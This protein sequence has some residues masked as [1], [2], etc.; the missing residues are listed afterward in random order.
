MFCFS[1][2]FFFLTS[3]SSSPD[4]WPTFTAASHVTVLLR[5][6]AAFCFP[7]QGR[8]EGLWGKPPLSSNAPPAIKNKK[9]KRKKKETGLPTPAWRPPCSLPAS[10]NKHRLISSATTVPLIVFSCFLF[11]SVYNVAV[12]NNDLL[13]CMCT[14]KGKTS[15]QS[16]SLTLID[17]VAGYSQ[18]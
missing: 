18:P 15:L 3:S 10:A 9:Q 12:S 8:E 13:M 1:F 11:G 6:K 17:F 5:E 16:H 2:F 7:V 4:T 14:N